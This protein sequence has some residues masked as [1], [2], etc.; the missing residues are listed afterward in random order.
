MQHRVTPTPSCAAVRR[1]AQAGGDLGRTRLFGFQL[2]IDFLVQLDRFRRR[3]HQQFP[4]GIFFSGGPVDQRFGNLFPLA[5][6]GAV[7]A[8]A[9]AADFIF[10]RELIAAVLENEALGLVLSGERCG[11][12]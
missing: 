2:G 10:S 6:L 11:R 3:C 5:A 12:V 1:K 4:L 7:V 9:V 8:N